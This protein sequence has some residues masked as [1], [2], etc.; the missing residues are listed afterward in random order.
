MISEATEPILNAALDCV[1]GIDDRGRVTFF[2]KSAERTFGYRSSEAVGRELADV[3]VPP[4]QRDAH[5]LGLARYLRTGTASILGRRIELMAMRADGTEFPVE[6]A[7]TRLEPP[8]GPG[9][10]GFVRD[11]TERVTAEEELRSAQRRAESIANQQASLRRVATLVARQ[12]TPEELFAGV[13][14]EVAQVLGV[15]SMTVIRYDAHGTMTPVGVWGKEMQF[16]LGLSWPLEETPVASVIWRTGQPASVDLASSPTSLAAEL[17]RKGF[18]FVTG[19]PIVVEGQLWGAMLAHETDREALP[20]GVAKRLER[21]TELVATA[22]ANATARTEL[23]AVQRRVIEAADA[24]RARVTRDLH[25]GAQQRFVNAL[26]NLQRAQQKWSVDPTRARELLDVGTAE[27]EEGVET[28]RELAAGIHPTILSDL[29]LVAALET[30]AAR[31]PIPVSLEIEDLEL[32]PS[33]GV[34]AYFFCSEA[35]TNVAKHADASSAF[36]RVHVAGGELKI[37]VRD[38]GIG[39]AEIGSGGSG[40]L[41]L[42]DRIGALG[43][44]IALSS[45]RGG[46]GTTLTAHI[47]VHG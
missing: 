17:Q 20:V 15:R 11:I 22:V 8:A 32:P 26:I 24:A 6:L 28:L 30:L 21:F 38:D 13:A 42:K 4:S 10:I 41:G 27:A 25:D 31:A 37:E 47:P 45:P 36:L 12:A 33:L 39:G 35:L 29:G 19:V 9:F 43:G 18:R 46:A 3:I 16:V 2:S 44:S 14:K 40:L 23:A 1:I 5:R 7:V 34:S